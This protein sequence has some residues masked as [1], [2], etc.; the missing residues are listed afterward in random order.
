MA[1]FQTLESQSWQAHSGCAVEVL[2]NQQHCFY[3]AVMIQKASGWGWGTGYWESRAKMP[4]SFSQM[5]LA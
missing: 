1:R 3:S 2:Q 4:G 5:F